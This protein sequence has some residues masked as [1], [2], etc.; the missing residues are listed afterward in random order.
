MIRIC[1]GRDVICKLGVLARCASISASDQPAAPQFT[2]HISFSASTLCS[3]QGLIALDSFLHRYPYIILMSRASIT[4]NRSR[5]L[6]QEVNTSG[7]L[8]HGQSARLDDHP[9]LQNDTLP[10]AEAE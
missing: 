3:V 10:P 4:S 8:D 7:A 2:E 1:H 5:T 9:L 6:S